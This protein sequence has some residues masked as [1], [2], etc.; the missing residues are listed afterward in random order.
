MNSIDIMDLYDFTPEDITPPMESIIIDE[1]I[2]SMESNKPLD[3]SIN[4][5][6]SNDQIQENPPFTS[7]YPIISGDS[8]GIISIIISSI[9][10]LYT[11]TLF[12]TDHRFIYTQR[13]TDDL[14]KSH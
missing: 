11:L 12:E 9:P 5:N 7:N 10:S 6:K 4:P 3:I 2:I 1:S 14:I 8:G 13:S